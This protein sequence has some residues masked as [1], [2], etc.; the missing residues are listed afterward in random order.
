M[1][2]I[3]ALAVIALMAKSVT[4]EIKLGVDVKAV[5]LA[6]D[7]LLPTNFIWPAGVIRLGE[8]LY[9]LFNGLIL[10]ILPSYVLFKFFARATP[11]R[12]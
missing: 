5:N 6:I 12:R 2:V 1:L 11:Q 10:C 8:V 9:V 3:H 4:G 7:L